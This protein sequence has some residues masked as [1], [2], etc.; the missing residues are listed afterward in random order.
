MKKPDKDDW[1]KLRRFLG[2]LKRTIKFPM[3]L[4][5]NRLNVLKWWVDASYA[6]HDDMQGHTGGTMSMGK[7]GRGSIIIISKKQNLNTKS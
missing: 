2:Y 6:S 4:R 3:I 7:D 1:K 5:A